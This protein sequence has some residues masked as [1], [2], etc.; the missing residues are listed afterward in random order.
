M[1]ETKTSET[2]RCYERRHWKS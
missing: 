2:L 1:Y